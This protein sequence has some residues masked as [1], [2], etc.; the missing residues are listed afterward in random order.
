[1]RSLIGIG[2]SY[3]SVS[4]VHP[5]RLLR[6]SCPTENL[7]DL[8]Q[9]VLEDFMFEMLIAQ[10]YISVSEFARDRRPRMGSPFGFPVSEVG[11]LVD[12]CLNCSYMHLHTER[13]SGMF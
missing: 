1:M 8:C 7:V 9:H 3:I 10:E 2:K 13:S 5:S 11:P 12:I 4:C 6:F